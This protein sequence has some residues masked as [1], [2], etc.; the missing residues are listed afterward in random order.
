MKRNL[1]IWEDTSIYHFAGLN[2]IVGPP[3]GVWGDL[4]G[5]SG[6]L[7]GVWGDLDTCGITAADRAIGIVVEDLIALSGEESP[8]AD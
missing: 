5:V 2:R 6:D 1:K 3:P 4:T 8:D 7:T